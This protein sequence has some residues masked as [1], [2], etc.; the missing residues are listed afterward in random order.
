MSSKTRTVL[1]SLHLLVEVVHVVRSNRVEELDVVVRVVLGHVLFGRLLW[2]LFG[3]IERLVGDR[4]I[5]GSAIKTQRHTY[6]DLHFS[7]QAIVDDQVVR[8]ANSAAEKEH[9]D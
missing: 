2:T 7:V 6:V 4:G 9:L 5:D 8:H 3:Q 1:T